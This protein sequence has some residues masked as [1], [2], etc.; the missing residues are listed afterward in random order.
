M[1]WRRDHDSDD[2][3]KR[4]FERIEAGGGGGTM[5]IKERIEKAVG[6]VVEELKRVQPTRRRKDCT[7]RNG[8]SQQ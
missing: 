5:G 4:Y 8:I 2:R 3:R 7:G 6:V 1:W